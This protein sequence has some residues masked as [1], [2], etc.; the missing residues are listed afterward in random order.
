MNKLTNFFSNKKFLIGSEPP[1][2]GKFEVGDL[3]VNTG[4]GAASTPMWICNKAGQPGEWS[5]V[6]VGSKYTTEKSLVVVSTAV[7]EV[8]MGIE[9]D[10]RYDTLLVFINDA[11]MSQGTDYLLDGN[12]IKVVG[13]EAWNE[14]LTNDFTFEFVVFKSIADIGEGNI[15]ISPEQIEDKSITLDKLEQSLVDALNNI[16]PLDLTPY[17]KTASNDLI[18][19][20]KTITGAINELFIN[21]NNGKQLIA[22]AIGNPLIDSNS[23][24]KAMSEAIL[25]HRRDTENEDDSKNLLY[26]MMIEDGFQVTNE[27]SIDDLIKLLDDSKID[28]SEV[29]QIECGNE[30]TY[31]LKT[32]GTVWSCGDN[33]YGQLGLGDETTRTLFTQVN[34]D[35]VKQIACG[36]SFAYILKND[37]SLWSCGCNVRGELGLDIS[38]S[39]TGKTTFTQVTDGIYNDVKQVICGSGHTFIIKNDGSI[40]SCGNNTSGCLG[41]DYDGDWPSFMPIDNMSNVSQIACGSNTSFVVKTDGTVWCCGGGFYGQLGLGENDTDNKYVFVQVP[42]MTNAKQV[43]CGGSYTFILKNDGTLWGTGKNYEG[44]LGLN[45]TNNRY[46]FTQ[47]NID[48]TK[49]ISCGIDCTLLLKNNGELW[50]SGRNN[51]GQLGLNDTNNR[52]IFTQVTTDV[53]QIKSGYYHSVL[54]KTDGT[55]WGCGWNR[56]GQLGLSDSDATTHTTFVQNAFIGSTRLDEYGINRLKLYYYLLD[57]EISVTE[58]MDINVMLNLLVNKHNSNLLTGYINSL[59]IIL[60]NK[61]IEVTEEDDMASLINKVNQEFNK[62][63]ESNELVLYSH[64]DMCEANSGG[65]TLATTV[66]TN[67]YVYTPEDDHIYFYFR[68]QYPQDYVRIYTNNSI[69]LNEYNYIYIEGNEHH[70][71]TTFWPYVYLTFKK[72]DGSS[73]K[74]ENYFTPTLEDEYYNGLKVDLAKYKSMGEC[75]IGVGMKFKASQSSVCSASARILRVYLTK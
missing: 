38:G 75:Y 74:S 69:D 34:I 37:G 17:Q 33:Y 50:A 39:G 68:A 4:S 9:F 8:E 62:K 49:H 24:F 71:A 56:L 61:G 65:W 36:G 64:G 14:N 48:D 46:T 22:S 70:S 21:A 60:T 12:K 45:D 44:Q 5:P 54:L 55:V 42:N 16:E 52:S 58:D 57:N 51:Y 11:Y 53:V 35:N 41:I 10:Y 23:T 13:D 1:T 6:G 32:D 7:S 15:V 20:N 2:Q 19:N 73:E 30:F 63:E 47:I 66:S 27:M 40:R 18:T 67:D 3:I 31:V 29:A 59:K 26:D 43:F 25:G 28:F 72:V